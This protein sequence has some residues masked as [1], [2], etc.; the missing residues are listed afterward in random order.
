MGVPCLVQESPSDNYSEYKDSWPPNR[1]YPTEDLQ[2]ED[3][4]GIW[5]KTTLAANNSTN[6]TNKKKATKPTFS[7]VPSAVKKVR[8]PKF[9]KDLV[10]KFIEQSDACAKFYTGLTKEQRETLWDFLGDV[11]DELLIYKA[12]RNS[13]QLKY[14]LL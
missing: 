14:G 8:V 13:A 3:L 1:F 6:E 11:K 10:A 2:W 9:D 12:G 5:P 7:F 4:P